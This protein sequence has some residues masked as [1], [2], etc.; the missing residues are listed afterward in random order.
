VIIRLNLD[1]PSE[2]IQPIVDHFVA[3][4]LTE[5]DA[6]FVGHSFK[7]HGIAEPTKA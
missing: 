4:V 5:W 6:E 2:A 1:V 7:P 3:K